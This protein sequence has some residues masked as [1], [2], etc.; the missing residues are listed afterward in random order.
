MKKLFIISLLVTLVIDVQAYNA[1]FVIDN[2]G[3]IIKSSTDKTVFI[4]DKGVT[5]D[6]TVPSIVTYDGTTYTVTGIT[7]TG[8]FGAKMTSITLP[9]TMDSIAELGFAKCPNLETINLGNNLRI[10]EHDAF[11]YCTNLK[12]IVIPN[13]VTYLGYNA[14]WQCTSLTDVTLSESLDTIKEGTFRDC[15]S[16]Q[17]IV[18]PNSVKVIGAYVFANCTNLNDVTLPN[19]LTRLV[20]Y[21]FSQCKSLANITLPNT[22]TSIENGTFYDCNSLTNIEYPNSLTSIGRCAFWGCSSLTEANL[23]DQLKGVGEMAFKNCTAL[24]LVRFPSTMENIV[25]YAFDG[26]DNIKEVYSDRDFYSH[27]KLT[28]PA[29]VFTD[30]VFASATLY[31]SN[32]TGSSSY[33]YSNVNYWSKFTNRLSEIE[34]DSLVYRYYANCGLTVVKCKKENGGE[35]VVIP[36]SIT[37]GNKKL[38]ISYVY[39]NGGKYNTLTI[40]K[41]VKKILSLEING[42]AVFIEGTPSIKTLEGENNPYI[43][44]SSETPLELNSN[45]NYVNK[46]AIFIIP[47]HSLSNYQ[48]AEAWNQFEKIYEVNDITFNYNGYECK[49]L[50][51]EDYTMHEGEFPIIINYTP[52]QTVRSISLPTTIQPIWRTKYE[53]VKLPNLL[54]AN[55]SFLESVTLP[56]YITEISDSLL[57]LSHVENIQIPSMVKRIGNSAFRSTHIS[58]IDLPD[59][60]EELD[61]WAFSESYLTSIK[62]PNKVKIIPSDCFWACSVLTDVDLTAVTTIKNN[63]FQHCHELTNITL[64]E[65]LTKIESATFH[66][67]S[68][69][70]NVKLPQSLTFIDAYA[71]YKCSSLTTINIP[72]SVTTIR[73]SAFEGCTSLKT[74]YSYRTTPIS[75]LEDVFSD[76]TYSSA[77]LYVPNGSLSAYQNKDYW[78]KFYN[79]VE[80]DSTTDITSVDANKDDDEVV[81]IYNINGTRAKELQRGVNIIKT[82]DGKTKKV[83]K[84]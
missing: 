45:G 21:S 54:L 10:I 36:D 69:L 15:S 65:T 84:R 53:V 35:D 82:K 70:S 63:S 41:T 76:D 46:D 47:A 68:S 38:A 39:C 59:G 62:I 4:Y 58:S 72:A 51:E 18:I 77:T 48:A 9:E 66:D 33:D 79:I 32:I 23:P 5:G 57:Y 6:V 67:C 25:N 8:F 3:Y 61:N 13:S 52:E 20:G 75:L 81:G 1:D 12:K 17:K 2:I 73:S 78:S 40:P 26:C 27:G 28:L 43:V 24:T 83:I 74:V 31:Y 80:M 7:E 56:K 30:S 49:T 60:L 44:L 14:F 34:I 71:F 37:F 11:Q 16:L 19:S 29:N 22:L 42:K 64:P 55:L 50:A